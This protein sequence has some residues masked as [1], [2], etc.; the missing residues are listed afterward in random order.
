MNQAEATYAIIEHKLRKDGTPEEFKKVKEIE[1]A[2]IASFDVHK[3]DHED[4]NGKA[5]YEF[6]LA[7]TLFLIGLSAKLEAE[8]L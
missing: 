3:A 2:L 6:K 7:A 8:E 4:A 5:S 1:A